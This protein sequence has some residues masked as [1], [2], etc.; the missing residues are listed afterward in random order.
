MDG[1]ADPVDVSGS[2]LRLGASP[3]LDENVLAHHLALFAGGEDRRSAARLAQWRRYS[4]TI[5]I[6]IAEI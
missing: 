2:R 5:T 1:D 6:L 3:I 4:R